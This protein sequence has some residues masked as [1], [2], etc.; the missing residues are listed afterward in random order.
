[1]APKAQ[2]SAVRAKKGEGMDGSSVSKMLGL[3]KYQA[4]HGKVQVTKS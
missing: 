4:E 3:L 1:M 2:G